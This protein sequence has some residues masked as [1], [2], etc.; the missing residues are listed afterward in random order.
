MRSRAFCDM[1]VI[2]RIVGS[3]SCDPHAS[4][5]ATSSEVG[6]TSRACSDRF[7]LVY[8]KF[9]NVRIVYGNRYCVSSWAA[10]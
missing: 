3:R 5:P 2:A 10:I 1:Y 9:V 4:Q 6:H 7:N 8:R